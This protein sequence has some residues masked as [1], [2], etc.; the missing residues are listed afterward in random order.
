[1]PGPNQIPGTNP[2]GLSLLRRAA[3][4]GGAAIQR[5]KFAHD[6]AIAD[7]QPRLFTT[8]LLVLRVAADRRVAVKMVVTADSGGTENAAVGPNSGPVADVHARSDHAVCTNLDV[9]TQTRAGVDAGGGMNAG[10]H[11]RIMAVLA[12]T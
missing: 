5:Y 1:M 8:E 7:F 2:G 4:A 3:A 9:L 11:G 6:I 10:T 12:R